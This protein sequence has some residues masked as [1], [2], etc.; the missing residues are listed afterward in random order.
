MDDPNITDFSSAGGNNVLN[1]TFDE[2]FLFDASTFYN[3]EQDNVPLAKLISRTNLLHQ[4]AGYPG[5]EYQPTT[6]TLSSTAD[7]VNGIYDNIDDT[8]IMHTTPEI[9]AII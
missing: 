1:R 5:E 3:W 4:Y 8:L 6:M 7:E 9:Y 2:S